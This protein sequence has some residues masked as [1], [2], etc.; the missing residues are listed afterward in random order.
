MNSVEG[1]VI[2]VTGAARGIGAAIAARLAETAEALA[3]T[4]ITEFDPSLQCETHIIQGDLGDPAAPPRIV[5]ETRARFGRIDGLVNAAGLTTRGSFINPSP[6]LFDRLFAVNARAPFQLMGGAIADMRAREE[7]GSIVNIQSM[8]AHG[9][10]PDLAIYSATK[11]A[12]QTLTTNAA[13]A[14]LGDHIRVNGINLGWVDTETERQLQEET[15][16]NGAGWMAE[17]AA[18]MPI[19]RYVSEDDTA[20]LALY[21]LSDDSAPMTGVSLDLEQIVMGGL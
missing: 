21:L 15:L 2:L 8:N 7:P 9:G 18:K 20:R 1:K 16:G 4:D 3:L 13:H 11:G 14:H 10:A 12:L 17:N 5:E 19:G 6:T